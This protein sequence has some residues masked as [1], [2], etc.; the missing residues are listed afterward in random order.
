MGV[1][2]NGIVAEVVLVRSL[3][4]EGPLRP[5][6]PH[7]L[8]HVKRA[9]VLQLGQTDVQGTEGTCQQQGLVRVSS[10]TEWKETESG[11]GGLKE[12]GLI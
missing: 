10:N 11:V 7:R 4:A 12:S 6:A 1:L 2:Q 3:N 5:H 9:D 8:T